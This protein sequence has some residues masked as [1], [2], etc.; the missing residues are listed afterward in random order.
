MDRMMINITRENR[1]K[2]SVL[3]I[4]ALSVLV[5]MGLAALAVD[6]GA[7]YTARAQLQVGADAAALAAVQELESGQAHYVAAQ[8]AAM[9]SVLT[10]PITLGESD[11]T[12]GKL[13]FA[14][15][16]F[17]PGVEPPNAV[18]VTARRT[19]GAPDGPLELFFGK[20]IGH[21]TVSV[22][23]ESI[24]AIDGRVSGIDPASTEAQSDLLPF[25]VK[26]DD[27]GHLETLDGLPLDAV[28]FE[29][30]HTT[31]AI[32]V[33][34]SVDLQIKVLGSQITYGPD[35]PTIPVVASAS[36]N[37]GL[38]YSPVNDGQPVTG[39]EELTFTGVAN[40]QLAV[41]ARATYTNAD[42]ATYFDST[43]YSN[44]GTPSVVVLRQGDMVP[45]YEGVDG[46]DEITEFLAPYMDATTR[47]VTIG[48]NDVIFLFEFADN[49]D[50]TASDF[51][52][53]VVLG[54]FTKV[55]GQDPPHAETRFVAN[56]GE[57]V[58][59]Y[60]YVDSE[61]PGN[62]GLV[63]LDGYSNGA[64]TI[65]DWIANGYPARF[66]IPPDPGYIELNG[67]PGITTS[68]KAAV[69]SR[70][71]DTVL[72][73]V[74]DSVIGQGDNATYRVPYFLA[75]EI[76]DE[77]LVGAPD[78]RHIRAIIRGIDTTN[79]V[80]DPSAPEHA[81]LGVKRIGR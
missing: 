3:I 8:F 29:V 16:D 42:G 19:A 46:Q 58:D 23:A 73:A 69:Q 2:G 65:S 7:V 9:N 30:D 67:C 81:S 39:G 20:V 52:D 72:I 21:D 50:S 80:I 5:L 25:A 1:E 10:T 59:F 49:L 60:P 63:S 41:Q 32:V 27:V 37:N 35:G 61:A 56:E 53:L 45:D 36:L 28:D 79:L 15:G 44:T 18:R 6:L 47:E 13:D 68:I 78:Q 17:A 31:G 14:T 55:A 4:F 11:V 64:S 51:Q 66:T 70:I 62:F 74:Y 77:N 26:M 76:V 12:T 33:N 40:V 57:I 24:A 22:Q 54:T 48:M 34:D 71:G 75:V 38:T 43:R